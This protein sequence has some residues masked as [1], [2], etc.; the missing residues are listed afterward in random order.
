MSLGGVDSSAFRTS[1]IAWVNKEVKLLD[2]CS[3]GCFSDKGS[4]RQPEW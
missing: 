3:D 2:R 1:G 4:L